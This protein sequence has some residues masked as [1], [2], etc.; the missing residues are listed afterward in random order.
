MG[1][2]ASSAAARLLGGSSD[3]HPNNVTA[4]PPTHPR[5][6]PAA[7]GEGP[8]GAAAPAAGDPGLPPPAGEGSAACATI[9]NGARS[10]AG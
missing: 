10:T 4:P 2:I 5:R 9:S 8:T 7:Q 6:L 1:G 3:K